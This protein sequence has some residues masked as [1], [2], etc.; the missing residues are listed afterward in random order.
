[1][2]NIFHSLESCGG[3]NYDSI[4]LDNISTFKPS[5]NPM[6]VTKKEINRV[7]MIK[8]N[9]SNDFKKYMED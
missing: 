4:T 1:M 2:Q 6:F 8:L 3:L 7:E 5:E 9:T